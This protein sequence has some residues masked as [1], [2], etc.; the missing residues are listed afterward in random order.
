MNW[1]QPAR[2]GGDE[3]GVVKSVPEEES[4]ER[5]EVCP[6]PTQHIMTAYVH[7][8]DEAKDGMPVSSHRRKFDEEEE[9]LCYIGKG[10][11]GVSAISDDEKVR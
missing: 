11:D 3:G 1:K 8:A 10:S 5:K 6:P 7:S 2:K 4:E 9:S